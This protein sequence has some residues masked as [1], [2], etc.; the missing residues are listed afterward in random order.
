M[1]CE[2]PG[3]VV[4]LLRSVSAFEQYS[5]QCTNRSPADAELHRYLERVAGTAR[6]LFEVALERIARAE[7]LALPPPSEADHR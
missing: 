2:C 3:H 1:D 7:G 5:A 6:T 4:E